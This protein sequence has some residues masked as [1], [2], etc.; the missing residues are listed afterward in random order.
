MYTLG[1]IPEKFQRLPTGSVRFCVQVKPSTAR[2]AEEVIV[3]LIER[4]AVDRMALGEIEVLLNPSSGM[5]VFR[6]VE[7]WIDP[8]TVLPR[9]RPGPISDLHH[10]TIFRQHWDTLKELLG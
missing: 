7:K 1:N 2:P 3:D 6:R 8:H 9:L 5:L 10:G 4:G